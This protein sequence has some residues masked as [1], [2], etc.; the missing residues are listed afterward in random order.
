MTVVTIATGYENKITGSLLENPNTAKQYVSP[1]PKLPN[2]DWIE[3]NQLQY[4]NLKTM[5]TGYHQH[6]NTDGTDIAYLFIIIRY[7]TSY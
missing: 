2:E 7:H 4:D 5:D 3:Y 1:S 6:F